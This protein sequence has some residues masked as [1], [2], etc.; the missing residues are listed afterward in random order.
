MLRYGTRPFLKPTTVYTRDADE[1]VV[2]AS[3]DNFMRLMESFR[4]IVSVNEK[5]AGKCSDPV[6]QFRVARTG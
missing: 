2:A 6:D 4:E 5:F 1:G 3:E